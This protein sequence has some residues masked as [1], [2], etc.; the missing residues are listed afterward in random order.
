MVFLDKGA[1]HN[2]IGIYGYLWGGS[3][4]PTITIKGNPQNLNINGQF[5]IKDATITSIPTEGR[6]YDAVTDNFTYIN[7]SSDTSVHI[8]GSSSNVTKDEFVAINPFERNRYTMPGKA[9]ATFDYLNLNM[10]VKTE[11]NMFVSIDFNN[12]TQDR[13]FGELIADV[14]LRTE[15]KQLTAYGN[16]DVVGDSYYR[17]YR[18]F[19]IKDS[20]ITFSGLVTKPILDIRAVYEGTGTKSTQQLG[21]NS[22]IPV[23]VELTVKGESD[24]AQVQLNLVENGTVVEGSDAQSDAVTYLLFGKFKSDLNASQRQAIASSLGTQLASLYVSSYISQEIRNVLPFIVDAEFNYYGGDVEN[25]NAALTSQFG[26]ATIKVG[27]R[28]VNSANYLEFTVDYPLN[29]L[30]KLNLPETLLLELAKEE[31][32]SSIIGDTEVH[33]STGLKLLYKIKF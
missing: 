5:L 1:K 10:N 28:L 13:L 29:K 21:V 3:G 24:T 9:I 23:E 8:P 33:Y 22:T 32:T 18:D 15:N 2:D 12:L 20:H 11:Q 31:L 19:K 16:I 6:G 7:A 14:N 4:K 17:F 27:S 26:E 25:T 30:L